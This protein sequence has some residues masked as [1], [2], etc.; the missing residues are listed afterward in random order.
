MPAS[1]QGPELKIHVVKIQSAI[2][3]QGAGHQIDCSSRNHLSMGTSGN[4]NARQKE[5]QELVFSAGRH[6]I[7][8]ANGGIS[9]VGWHHPMLRGLILRVSDGAEL[10]L[11]PS[12]TSPSL[13]SSSL[14][15]SS[16]GSSSL[17]SSNLGSSSLGRSLHPVARRAPLH[18]NHT[19]L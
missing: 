5:K 19:L 8:F 10:Q 3:Q 9:A 16:L 11:S 17:G 6:P 7:H 2:L 12:L 4:P 18:S 14:G 1:P 13:G 15:S